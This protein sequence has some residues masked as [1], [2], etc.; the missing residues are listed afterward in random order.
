L[1]E[2]RDTSP[3][4]APDADGA[5]LHGRRV[6][7]LLT[8]PFVFDT[9]V[10]N[11]AAALVEAGATVHVI[12]TRAPDLPH[13][14]S[15][16]ALHVHRVAAGRGDVQR[17]LRAWALGPGALRNPTDAHGAHRPVSGQADRR[18][19]PTSIGLLA[20]D[21]AAARCACA[22]TPDLVV[23]H[24][25][26]TLL[27]GRL[28]KRWMRCGLLYDSH[29]LFLHRSGAR[30]RWLSDRR[31]W[32]RIERRDI[33]GCDAVITVSGGI[34][35]HLARRYGIE[36]PVVIRNVQ[37]WRDVPN[38]NRLREQLGLADDTRI[39]LYI[40]AILPNRGLA[41]L[42]EAAPHLARTAV[43]IM[44]PAPS[45]TDVQALHDQARACGAT[46]VHLCDPVPR[47]E[48]LD[49]ASSADLSVVP[50]QQTCLSHAY[51]ASNKIFHS[52][53][54]GVPLAMSDHP[55][56]RAIVEAYDVGVLFDETD[57]ASMARA[58]RGVLDDPA[59]HAQYA[60]ACR[61]AARTLNWDVE[62]RRY[63]DVIQ[64]VFECAAESPADAA[65]EEHDADA[66]KG[67]LQ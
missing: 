41:Q 25:L 60:A 56:K 1:I 8:N 46:N 67:Q 35:D 66:G 24:D 4:A 23:A 61:E 49:V 5:S 2:A 28:C 62:Q 9:R 57:P 47:D 63:L 53:M 16:G 36:P 10:M 6:V 64:S 29:E 38:S 32:S 14:E 19:L 30:R 50:T 22:L 13:A 45:R 20:Y 31:V 15:N 21:I 58:I 55:E 65:G 51:E 26:D 43:V 34:R 12:A 59:A 7:M 40:G 3:H 33:H 17:G 52:I 27:A 44:G 11:Q 54:A 37:P 48:V 42:I 18:C 39:V